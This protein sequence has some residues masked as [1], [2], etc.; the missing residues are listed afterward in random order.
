MPTPK[1]PHYKVPLSFH[2]PKGSTKLLS[3]IKLQ[4]TNTWLSSLY[5]L[6]K[7]FASQSFWRG[8]DVNPQPG[9]SKAATVQP[10]CRASTPITCLHEKTPPPNPCTK[11]MPIW[12]FASKSCSATGELNVLDSSMSTG[13]SRLRVGIS[14]DNTGE[15]GEPSNSGAYRE[16]VGNLLLQLLWRWYWV[17]DRA[18][19]DGLSKIVVEDKERGGEPDMPSL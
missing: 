1:V 19:N 15:V 16:E 7:W 13:S 17:L 18:F 3:Q 6:G 5:G 4:W 11:T 14:S 12:P 8:L 2:G 9:R 10:T